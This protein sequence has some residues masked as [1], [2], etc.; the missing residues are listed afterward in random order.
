MDKIVIYT[1]GDLAVLLTAATGGKS[2]DQWLSAIRVKVAD[3]VKARPDSYLSFGPY[4]W[5]VKAQLV[6]VGLLAGDVNAE[7]A[8][9]ITSGDDATDMAGAVAYHGYNVDEMRSTDQFT[10][11]TVGGDQV[12]YVLDDSDMR[13]L[14]ERG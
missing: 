13:A 11:D 14:I 2:K 7:L 5:V 3:M 9:A 12:E 10:V 8:A 6:A 4:W 1:P